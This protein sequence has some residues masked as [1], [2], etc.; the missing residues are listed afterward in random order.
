MASLLYLGGMQPDATGS[1]CVPLVVGYAWDGGWP[2]AATSDLV[3]D[4]VPGMSAG[5]VG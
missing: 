4:W 1:G 3:E 5:A 2:I